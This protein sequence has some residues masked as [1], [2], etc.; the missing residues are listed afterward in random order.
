MKRRL[1]LARSLIHQ[2]KILLLDEPTTGIDLELRYFTWN[3]LKKINNIGTTII[4]TTHYLEEAE[5]LCKGIA[6]INKGKILT[7]TT[8]KNLKNEMNTKTFIFESKGKIP[9]DLSFGEYNVTKINNFKFAVK[10]NREQSLNVFLKYLEEKSIYVDNII[11]KNNNLES[12][13]FNICNE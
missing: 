12:F 7:N 4:L 5:K 13:F 6:I 9:N 10:I 11:N 2:P 8:I 3:F 1:M